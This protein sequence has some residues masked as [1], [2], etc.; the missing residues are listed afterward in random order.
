MDF[1]QAMK[2][3]LMWLGLGTPADASYWVTQVSTLVILWWSAHILIIYHNILGHKMQKN[4][5]S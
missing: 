3:Q 4:T 1:S 2:K 5:A